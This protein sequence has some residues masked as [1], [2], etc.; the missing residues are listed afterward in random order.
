[1]VKGCTE[2]GSP[3]GE[4]AVELE[5]GGEE[6][7]VTEKRKSSNPGTTTRPIMD[8]IE[9][10]KQDYRR[11]PTNQTYSLY[12][13]NVYFKDPLNEFRGI[14]RYQAMIKFISTWFQ[15]VSLELHQI[16]RTGDTIYTEWTLH[17]T[18]PVPWKPPIA[19]P[20]RSELMV[21]EQGKIASHIDYWHCSRGDVVKQHLFPRQRTG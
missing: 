12:A 4:V 3:V 10:L 17:W 6:Q 11:F 19:I 9:I 8:L 2:I 21:D 14:K 7:A 1:M 5:L 13:E 16:Y 20:G 15:N 18:T